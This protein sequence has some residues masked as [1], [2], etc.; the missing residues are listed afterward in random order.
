MSRFVYTRSYAI[1]N[2]ITRSPTLRWISLLFGYTYVKFFA[3][4]Y[5]G[6]KPNSPQTGARVTF[7]VYKSFGW[8]VELVY[9]CQIVSSKLKCLAVAFYT[10]LISV[11][12]WP[13]YILCYVE[14]IRPHRDVLLLYGCRNGT[15]VSK[16][17]LVEEILDNFPNGLHALRIQLSKVIKINREKKRKLFSRYNL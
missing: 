15:E 3:N 14:F 1:R 9:W 12:R 10:Q 16:V 8:C 6:I 2:F 5:F 13:Q 17:H 11:F 4:M 7:S